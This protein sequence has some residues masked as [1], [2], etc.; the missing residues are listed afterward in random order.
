M[1]PATPGVSNET[2][3]MQAPFEPVADMLSLSPKQ[4]ADRLKVTETTRD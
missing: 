3:G 1:S 2:R 4:G